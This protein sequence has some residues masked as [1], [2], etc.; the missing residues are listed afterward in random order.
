[1]GGGGWGGVYVPACV[2]YQYR[3][4]KITSLVYFQQVV[5]VLAPLQP[6]LT[7]DTAVCSLSRVTNVDMTPSCICHVSIHD[8]LQMVKGL[9]IVF[10]KGLT[11]HYISFYQPI[12]FC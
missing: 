9:H 4:G 8:V 2:L 5:S 10:G 1:M 7:G 3:H 11:F 12:L 6:R